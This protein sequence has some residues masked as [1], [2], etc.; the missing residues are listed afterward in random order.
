MRV[1]DPSRFG[2]EGGSE[3]FKQLASINK[4]DIKLH[5][6]CLI[7]DFITWKLCCLNNRTSTTPETA[8]DDKL[9]GSGQIIHR[10]FAKQRT[11]HKSPA[12]MMCT[13]DYVLKHPR[14][15]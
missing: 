6:V 10:P 12:H 8:V 3:S 4:I 14:V 13:Q 11:L 5:R 1:K 15:P 2:M 7:S 9:R